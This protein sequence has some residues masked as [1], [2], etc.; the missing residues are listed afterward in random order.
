M[1]EHERKSCTYTKVE[2][3]VSDGAGLVA[4]IIVNIRL[5]YDNSDNEKALSVLT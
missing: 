2:R 3:Q 4:S 5:R 1:K